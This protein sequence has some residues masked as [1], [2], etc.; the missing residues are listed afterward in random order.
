MRLGIGSTQAC[1]G[2]AGLMMQIPAPI[3]I[4]QNVIAAGSG[5]FLIAG[6]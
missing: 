6:L 5:I 1:L 3:A 2:A 4:A